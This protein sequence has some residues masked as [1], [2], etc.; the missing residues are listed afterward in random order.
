[1]ASP[2]VLDERVT[3]YDDAG[4]P[5]LFEV[6]H[7]AESGFQ[8]P[9]VGFDPVVGVLGGVVKCSRQELHD[10]PD[11]GVGPVGRDLGWRAVRA[12]GRGEESGR[13][14]RVALL[15]E[16]STSM[17]WPYWSTARWTYLQRPATFT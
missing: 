10:H 13:S 6:P 7:R 16:R 14:R 17:T 4:G 1:M 9:V 3:S 12:D 8:A 2:K 5:V 11:R 15:I